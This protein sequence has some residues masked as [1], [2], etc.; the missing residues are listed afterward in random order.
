MSTERLELIG[1]IIGNYTITEYRNAGS[2]GAVY[3]AKHNISN[4]IVALKI[5]ETYN[6]EKFY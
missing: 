1:K 2:F 5:P 6:G 4:K 3:K